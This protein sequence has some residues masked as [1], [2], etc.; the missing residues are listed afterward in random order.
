MD[1]REVATGARG[2]INTA[3]LAQKENGLGFKP[4]NQYLIGYD[5]AYD[6]WLD[7]GMCRGL[8]IK[9]LACVKN[10]EE[11]TDIV[12]TASMN[13]FT[14]TK[15]NYRIDN[16]LHQEIYNASIEGNVHGGDDKAFCDYV[17][18]TYG[19]NKD[20]SQVFKD[21]K[22]ATVKGAFEFAAHDGCYSIVSF[23]R[24]ALAVVG[25]KDIKHF[26]EPNCGIIIGP[27][28]PFLAAIDAFFSH[29]FVQAHL[30]D[31]RPGVL[32]QGQPLHGLSRSRS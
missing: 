9:Y 15:D 29:Q 19:L 20:K 7:K 21:G 18:T 8:S 23:P 28:E 5:A 10:G 16:P 4:F 12:T 30:Q 3:A 25:V 11:F 17:K 24:H 2:V 32:D 26:L 27:K 1:V 31:D 14:Y 22:A 13:K 6:D